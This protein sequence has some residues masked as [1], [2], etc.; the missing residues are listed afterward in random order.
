M[1]PFNQ[2]NHHNPA[3]MTICRLM[4]ALLFLASAAAKLLAPSAT[5]AFIASAG[6]PFPM[7]AFL[8]AVSVEAG[9]GL[10]LAGGIQARIVAISLAIFSI[11]TGLVFHHDL[12]NQMQLMELMKN[13]AIAGG[14]LH[15]AAL[16]VPAGSI[17][18]VA[19]GNTGKF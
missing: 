11:A 5:I 4:I 12:G 3:A 9:G 14:L 19:R 15:I 8:I 7:L 2:L 17:P 1:K 13:I 10:L 6:L 16:N 18:R